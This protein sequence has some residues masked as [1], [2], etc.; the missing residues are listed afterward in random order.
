MHRYLKSVWK[1]NVL[2]KKYSDFQLPNLFSNV[3]EIYR[4]Q[5][6]TFPGFAAIS[7]Y[8]IDQILEEFGN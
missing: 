1:I 3:V 4:V 7:V 8:G 6:Y 2:I 5:A